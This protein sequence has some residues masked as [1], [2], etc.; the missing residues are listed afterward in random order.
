[1]QNASKQFLMFGNFRQ[2]FE[3]NVVL[4]CPLPLDCT[5]NKLFIIERQILVNLRTLTSSWMPFGPLD[6]MY[7]A[8]TIPQPCKRIIY[9]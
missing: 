4:N 3:I 8:L 5:L 1:M 2:I 7:S 6:F 9:N